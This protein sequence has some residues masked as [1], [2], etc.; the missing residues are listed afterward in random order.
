MM[1]KKIEGARFEDWVDTDNIKVGHFVGIYPKT[2]DVIYEITDIYTDQL[3]M[4]SIMGGDVKIINRGD[5]TQFVR[6]SNVA[7]DGKV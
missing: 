6:I 4:K 3:R 2:L 5:E 1:E 7:E